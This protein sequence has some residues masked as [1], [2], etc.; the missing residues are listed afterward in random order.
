M[1]VFAAPWSDE[2]IKGSGVVKK[3]DR[4]ATNFTG[5]ELSLP[6]QVELR[7]GDK[8]SVT[9]EA[10]DNILPLVH[11]G[12]DGGTLQLRASRKNLAFDT[13]L[14]R[15]VVT[16]RDIRQLSVG[17]SGSITGSGLKAPRLTLEI[18]GGGSIDMKRVQ[19]NTLNASIGGSGNIKLA[20]AARKLSVTIG[21]SGDVQ[22]GLMRADEASVTIGGSGSAT[23]WLVN[24]LRTVIAGSGD[25]N[26]YGDPRTNN[27]IVGS[28][29]IKRLGAAP[30]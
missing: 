10:D 15:I 30:Q 29:E 3:Q 6:A 8:E 17:G 22:A 27:T 11:V 7:M 14:I 4:V 20:G 13:H 25:V 18:G 9:V 2:T 24:A 23:L 26:Y 5:I 21:G 28:G 16:A 19:S 12:V 1:P